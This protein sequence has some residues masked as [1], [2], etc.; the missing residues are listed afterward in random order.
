MNNF[1]QIAK[2]AETTRDCSVGS[3]QWFSASSSDLKNKSASKNKK[4]FVKRVTFETSLN[5]V[6]VIPDA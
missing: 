4:D 2:N 1:K 3:Q 6:S 5:S